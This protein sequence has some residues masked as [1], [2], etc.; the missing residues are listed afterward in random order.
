MVAVTTVTVIRAQEPLGSEAEARIWL[1]RL[2]EDEFIQTLLD[3]ALATVDRAFA[4]EAAATGRPYAES[5]ALGQILSARVGFGDGDHVSEGR[6]TEAM[7]VDARGGTASARRERLARTRPLA[8]IAAIIGGKD[9]A[10]ACEYLIPRVR[11][12]L[13]ASRVLAAALAIENAVRATVVEMDGVLDEPDHE[14]DLD[15]IE[16]MLPDLTVMTDTLLADP[17]VWAGLADSLE[18]PLLIAERVVRRQ[19]ILN[20]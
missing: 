20:Q 18:E 14:R 15:R 4:A 17:K 5:P 16:A 1:T 11:A 3:E 10:R 12:D 9:S 2:E 19:R 7:E 13:D 6:F 8:R